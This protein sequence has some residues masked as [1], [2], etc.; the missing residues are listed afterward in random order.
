VEYEGVIY[1]NR[2]ISTK[3]PA[4]RKLHAGYLLLV[5]HLK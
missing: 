1:K 3:S 5:E 4:F 2:I